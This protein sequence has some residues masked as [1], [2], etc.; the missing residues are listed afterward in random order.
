MYSDL[1]FYFT[2]YLCKSKLK[3]TLPHKCQ[4]GRFAVYC[5]FGY[6]V[7]RKRMFS[8]IEPKNKGKGFVNLLHSVIPLSLI[9]STRKDTTLA[10]LCTI[11]EVTILKV[12]WCLESGIQKNQ[13]AEYQV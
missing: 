3:T 9:V 2:N 13:V 4:C 8:C 7:P 6:A 5:T 1:Y 10:F 12:T 11:T